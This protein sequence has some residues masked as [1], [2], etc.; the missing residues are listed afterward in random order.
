MVN[1]NL[2]FKP[3]FLNKKNDENSRHFFSIPH[4]C[5][6]KMILTTKKSIFIAIHLME[7]TKIFAENE[8]L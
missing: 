7:M 6:F 2:C 8:G 1:L 5:T 4:I 3:N